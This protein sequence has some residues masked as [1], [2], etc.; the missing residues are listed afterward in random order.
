M[1]KTINLMEIFQDLN[2]EDICSNKAYFDSVFLVE[3][4]KGDLHK[5]NLVWSNAKS[6]FYFC[7]NNYKGQCKTNYIEPSDIAYVEVL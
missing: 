2:I 5:V 3:T 7:I 6:Q 4:I 1:M